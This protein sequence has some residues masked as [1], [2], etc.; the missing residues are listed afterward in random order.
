MNKVILSILLYEIFKINASP[1]V[2]PLPLVRLECKFV[3]LS[4]ESEAGAFVE[5]IESLVVLI[6]LLLKGRLQR[7]CLFF[8]LK[9]KFCLLVALDTLNLLRTLLII[10][11][12]LTVC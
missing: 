5:E 2:N 10:T 4:H 3:E 7:R 9:F 8:F 6:A 12:S 1:L 11:C